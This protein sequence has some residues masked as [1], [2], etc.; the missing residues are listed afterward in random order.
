VGE[1]ALPSGIGRRCKQDWGFFLLFSLFSLFQR[2]SFCI[3]MKGRT[4]ECIFSR[5]ACFFRN[6]LIFLSR[7]GYSCF[8]PYPRAED[9]KNK[10]RQDGKKARSGYPIV[11]GPAAWVRPTSFMKASKNFN[12][13]VNLIQGVATLDY[14]YLCSPS[15]S[16]QS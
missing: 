3:K 13:P 2:A 15:E 14:L 5:V 1:V 10:V 4:L 16:R 7:I 6:L 12:S 11:S 8:R 9:S